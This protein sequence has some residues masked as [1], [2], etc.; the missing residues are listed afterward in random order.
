M[1]E[2]KEL[3][4]QAY[5]H[6]DMSKFTIGPTYV[7]YNYGGMGYDV[8]V[9][10]VGPGEKVHHYDDSASAIENPL[11]T[12]LGTPS[13]SRLQ[14]P[15][16][17]TARFPP[18]FAPNAKARYPIPAA[19]INLS[20]KEL[21]T[22]L[23]ALLNPLKVFVAPKKSFTVRLPDV[24]R[25][26]PARCLKCSR[27]VGVAARAEPPYVGSA[28]Q[29]RDLL[30]CPPPLEGKFDY[31]K[32]FYSESGLEALRREF[33]LQD[34]PDFRF[35]GKGD[36]VFGVEWKGAYYKSTHKRRRQYDW[37]VPSKGLGLTRAGLGRL[38]RSIEAYVYCV[39]AA[40]TKTRSTIVDPR[41]D[42]G[43]AVETQQVFA[44][45]FEQAIEN[46]IPQSVQ[47]FQRAVV[48]ARVRLDI[49]ISPGLWLLPS[50][51]EINQESVLGYNN[52][53][54][55]ATGDMHFG[56]N[57]G[58]NTETHRFLRQLAQGALAPM[59]GQ[60]GLQHKPLPKAPSGQKVA[61]PAAP[62]VHAQALPTIHEKNLTVVG[63]A[64]A[65]LGWWM[66]R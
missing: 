3:F 7:T 47:R 4:R 32:N 54:K 29:P 38:N 25:E 26:T 15:V 12:A 64:A 34:P 45:L 22:D 42:S 50:N 35:K 27:D 16:V 13:S 36:V 60:A 46:D 33:D 51:L 52:G 19:A 21:R 55:K 28:T 11:Q 41:S 23:A 57:P 17:P 40:Q 20:L 58:L 59:A 14:K 65:G 18:E 61:E 6:A 62:T 48:D 2:T 10:K 8:F 9:G 31:H 66:L 1:V 49:A 53:L 63:L 56:Q 37:F 44:T 24:F 43:G 39:L 5:P 30:G